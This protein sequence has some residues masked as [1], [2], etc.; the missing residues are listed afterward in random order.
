MLV[1]RIVAVRLMGLKES[2]VAGFKDISNAFA[3]TEDCERRE[4]VHEL[5]A[6]DTSAS[7]VG[8]V[9]RTSVP[10]GLS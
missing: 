8:G 9:L 6:E 5:I 4:V 3:C 7:E 2:F 10:T 1:L